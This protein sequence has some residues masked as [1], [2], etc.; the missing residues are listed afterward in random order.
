MQLRNNYTLDVY[1]GDTGVVTAVDLEAGEFQVSFDDGRAV[2]YPMDEADNLAP[3]YCATVHKAQGSEY[4]AVVLSL[5]NQHFMLLQ[6]N[7]LYTAVTRGRR[8]VVIVGSRRAVARAVRNTSQTR[9]NTR[10]AA[11]L[12]NEIR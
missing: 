7:V 1:N 10:L 9:R 6:R 2:L 5:H 4:P 11:R 3:A 8:L 12:R